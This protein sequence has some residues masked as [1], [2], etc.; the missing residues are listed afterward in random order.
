VH[1][2]FLERDSEGLPEY[3]NAP[4]LGTDGLTDS[5]AIP[6]DGVCKDE[7]VA[8]LDFF[9]NGMYTDLLPN[10]ASQWTLLLSVSTE[11]QFPRIRQRA[12]HELNTNYKIDPVEEIVLARQFD[13]PEWRKPAYEALVQREHGPTH[14][15]ADRLG[16]KTTVSLYM[17]REEVR[18][19]DGAPQGP[20][21]A[22]P[23]DDSPLTHP[24]D[25]EKVSQ[26]VDDIF[27]PSPIRTLGPNSSCG[28]FGPRSPP[29]ECIGLE[30]SACIPDEGGWSGLRD[31]RDALQPM[32]HPPPDGVVFEGVPRPS[33][34]TLQHV[35]ANISPSPETGTLLAPEEE[36]IPKAMSKKCS[37]KKEKMME[38]KKKLKGK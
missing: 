15:E 27:F 32:S 1:R 36:E 13:I 23:L 3:I 20:N 25:P 9:Y 38:K 10:S 8:L 21:T 12:I 34:D 5:T 6:L 26:I 22:I 16:I 37:S 17:A 33:G 31:F 35:A 2:F 19:G 18:K 4:P 29:D 14:D 28:L 11:C 24:Y 7:F 30:T